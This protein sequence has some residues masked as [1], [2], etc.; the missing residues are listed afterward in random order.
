MTEIRHAALDEAF[1][2]S[3]ERFAQTYRDLA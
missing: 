3:L 2:W 1:E